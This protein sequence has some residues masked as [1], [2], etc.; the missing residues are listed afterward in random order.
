M[1]CHTFNYTHAPPAIRGA[2][3]PIRTKKKLD[4]TDLFDLDRDRIGFL[5]YSL[6]SI[7]Y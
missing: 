4:E 1:C 3:G 6:Q 7:I 2:H 5:R